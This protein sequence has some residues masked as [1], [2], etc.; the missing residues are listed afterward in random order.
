MYM[1]DIYQREIERNYRVEESV[2]EDEVRSYLEAVVERV[3]DE[4]G[5]SSLDLVD[6]VDMEIDKDN[7]IVTSGV[8][9]VSVMV[10]VDLD[11][12]RVSN[13]EAVKIEVEFE[14]VEDE[15]FSSKI[16]VE[17]GVENSLPSSKS[18]FSSSEVGEYVWALKDIVLGVNNIGE[19]VM[20]D[21]FTVVGIGADI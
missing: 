3:D 10:F 20:M 19:S 5:L 17:V 1:T 14:S 9:E 2:A 11:D 8:D 12:C 16:E 4:F 18:E 21:K 13:R 6:G 15:E 7:P